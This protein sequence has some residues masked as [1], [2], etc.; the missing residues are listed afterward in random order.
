MPQATELA[1]EVLSWHSLIVV[2]VTTGIVV[3]CVLLHY[4]AF[5][6]LTRA[7]ARLHVRIRRRRILLLMFGLLA[8]HIVEI[9]MFA[10]GYWSLADNRAFGR[11]HGAGAAHLVD[12]VYYSTVCYTT[13][14]LG[15]LYPIGAIRFMTGMEALSGFLLITWSA[16]FTFLEMQRFWKTD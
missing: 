1:Q 9:W 10:F 2:L 16:S 3:A 15:D 13:L 11:L 4:E 5:A 6:L 7:L 8:L 14:G 12:Y